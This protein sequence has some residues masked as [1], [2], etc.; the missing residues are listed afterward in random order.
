MVMFGFEVDSLEIAL[1]EQVDMVDR[2]FL[3]EA[4]ATH[5]GVRRIYTII[6]T[7]TC[8]APAPALATAP[9]SASAH[10]QASKPLLWERLKFTPRFSFVNSSKVGW[11]MK[12]GE[13]E[14]LVMVTLMQVEHVV[15]MVMVV[16]VEHVVVI[17][18]T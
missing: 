12:G 1:R 4:T 15:V 7:N 2:L 9:S 11:R 17:R 14:H 10:Y 5:K 3:V 16:Q 18:L 8:I 13:V 6:C